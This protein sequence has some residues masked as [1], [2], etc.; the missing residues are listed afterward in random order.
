MFPLLV[1]SGLHFETTLNKP[2]QGIME[3]L[4]DVDLDQFYLFVATCFLL[5]G[6]VAVP[7]QM[8]PELIARSTV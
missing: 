2:K 3:G 5:P 8:V 7:S 1:T 4:E 6:F